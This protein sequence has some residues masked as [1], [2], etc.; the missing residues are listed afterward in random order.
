KDIFLELYTT[1][2]GHCKRMQAAWDSL[3]K[4]YVP[5]KDKITMYMDMSDNDLL[6]S[7]PFQVTGF[8]TI[9]FKPAGTRTFIN[10]DRSHTLKDFSALVEEHAVNSLGPV[11]LGGSVRSPAEI[12]QY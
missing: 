5:L 8:P 2:C 3:A 7:A 11:A 9:K 12:A 4:K 6:P 1:W 10:Y